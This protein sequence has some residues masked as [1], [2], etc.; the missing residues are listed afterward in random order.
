MFKQASVAQETKK[1]VNCH[2]HKE[3]KKKNNKINNKIK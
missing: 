2:K 3:Q 1:H